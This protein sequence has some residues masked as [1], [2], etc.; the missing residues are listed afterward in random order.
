MTETDLHLLF[1]R[2]TGREYIVPDLD[3]IMDGGNLC[4]YLSWLEEKL[5]NLLHDLDRDR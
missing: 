5:L 2:E 1:R 4:D 3:N